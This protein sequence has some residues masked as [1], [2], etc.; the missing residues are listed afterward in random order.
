V[1]PK[2]ST[3]VRLTDD[4]F[5]F[6]FTFGHSECPKVK[7]TKWSSVSLPGIESSSLCL[8]FET[9]DKNWLMSV[10]RWSYLRT[11]VQ[12]C[13]DIFWLRSKASTVQRLSLRTTA[14]V[15]SRRVIYRVGQKSDTA[16][17]MYYIVRAVSLFWPTLYR[18]CL[19]AVF[20]YILTRRWAFI[21]VHTVLPRTNSGVVEFWD[22]SVSSVDAWLGRYGV[23]RGAASGA[24][25]AVHRGPR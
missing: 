9:L 3:P 17:T 24:Q 23:T 2:Y 22:I 7:K 10:L 4:H 1:F 14:F 11:A 5:S 18:P 13:R 16:R 25:F 12:I 21:G 8:H 19:L 6:F 15:F 20:V